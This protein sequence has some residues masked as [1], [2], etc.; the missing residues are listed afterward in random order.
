MIF[1]TEAGLGKTTVLQR[2]IAETRSPRRRVV[3][4]GP[5]SDGPQIPGL[6]AERLG[7]PVGREASHDASRRA[8]VRALRVARLQGL[9]VILAIDDGSDIRCRW[10]FAISMCWLTPDSVKTAV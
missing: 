9:Q 3:L 8:M 1:R 2:A 6:I 4:V 7:H 10:L 5:T